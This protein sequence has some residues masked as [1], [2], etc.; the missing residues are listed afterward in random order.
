[1][2]SQLSAVA[3]AALIAANVAGLTALGPIES[4]Q[5]V[6]LCHLEVDPIFRPVL[7]ADVA[8]V[9]HIPAS[10]PQ[11]RRGTARTRQGPTRRP[12]SVP[13]ISR[14]AQRRNVS[15]REA[16]VRGCLSQIL[17]RLSQIAC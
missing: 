2:R 13:A 3:G 8:I 14:R 5:F 11:A 7:D 15:A 4:R 6:S 10:M 1:M 9:T 16:C 12:G 17:G